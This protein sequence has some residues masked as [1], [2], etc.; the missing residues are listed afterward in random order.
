MAGLDGVGKSGSPLRWASSPHYRFA[1]GLIV[2]ME[3]AILRSS[4]R[5]FDLSEWT[6]IC[7]PLRLPRFTLLVAP[8]FQGTLRTGG[9][10]GAPCRLGF[11]E[12][13]ET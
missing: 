6:G 9:K 10:R 7:P 2:Q 12:K 8:G 11:D 3:R 5:Y 13:G 1:E 4:D